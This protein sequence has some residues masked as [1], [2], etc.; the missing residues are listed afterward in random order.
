MYYTSIFPLDKSS[1]GEFSN[2]QTEKHSQSHKPK[3]DEYGLDIP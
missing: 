3:A 1:F 2:A